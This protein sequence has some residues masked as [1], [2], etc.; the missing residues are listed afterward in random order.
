MASSACLRKDSSDELLDTCRDL[1]ESRTI[2]KG[3]SGAALVGREALH[4]VI[5]RGGTISPFDLV[6]Y[7]NGLDLPSQIANAFPTH[8][9]SAATPTPPANYANS[10][11]AYEAPCACKI[12][13]HL[14]DGL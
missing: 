8:D 11:K 7:C 13:D 5:L 6:N 1:E 12:T 4:G 2:E 10:S 3:S 9:T 14:N